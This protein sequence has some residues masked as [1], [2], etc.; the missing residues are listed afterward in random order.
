MP[1]QSKKTIMTFRIRVAIHCLKSGGVI[2]HPTDTIQS[3]G[4]L[5]RFPSAVKKLVNMKG[6]NINKGLILLTS[7]VRY[8]LPYI[9][10]KALSQSDFDKLNGVEHIPTTY[11]L[12]SSDIAPFYLTGGQNTVAIRVT[13]NH[14]VKYLCDNTQSALVSTSANISSFHVAKTILK[15]RAYFGNMIDAI[16]PPTQGNNKP[17][18]IIDLLTGERYR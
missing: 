8:A 4:C 2:S 9:D 5:P 7:D 1:P 16:L 13:T 6:R 14:L 18:R 3:V 15:L 12:P 10:V 17:S 11:I